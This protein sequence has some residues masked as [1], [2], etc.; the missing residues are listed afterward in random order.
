MSTTTNGM[1]PVLPWDVLSLMG[2]HLGG[3]EARYACRAFAEHEHDVREALLSPL[4][5]CSNC[6]SR[7]FLPGNAVVGGLWNFGLRWELKK[8]GLR[9][10]IDCSDVPFCAYKEALQRTPPATLLIDERDSFAEVSRTEWIPWT[11]HARSPSLSLVD[12]TAVSAAAF[13][14]RVGRVHRID[15]VRTTYET[16]E[17]I[18]KDLPPEQH[19]CFRIPL[20][21]RA[22][23]RK[24]GL[25]IPLALTRL[26][27]GAWFKGWTQIKPPTDLHDPSR[28]CEGASSI[29]QLTKH[30]QT[31]LRDRETLQQRAR[32]ALM[33]R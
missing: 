5:T 15:C 17:T 23:L 19:V 10:E 20:A 9:I 7:A 26:P 12:M 13:L 18:P 1:P 27:C 11:D 24:L 32:D 31:L 25:P 16:V 8:N 14:A 6:L 29:L 4:T 2:H 28:S 21:R 3:A 33:G 22:R 30:T